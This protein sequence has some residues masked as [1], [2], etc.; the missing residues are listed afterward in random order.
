MGEYASWRVVIILMRYGSCG[1]GVQN[2]GKVV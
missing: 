2:E 1:G